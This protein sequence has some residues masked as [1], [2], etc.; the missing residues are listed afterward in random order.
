MTNIIFTRVFNFVYRI[1]FLYK[2]TSVYR[3]ELKALKIMHGFT[4]S[5]IKSRREELLK[6]KSLK[7][8]SENQEGKKKFAFLD[9]LLQ[10]VNSDGKPLTN[11]DIREEVDTFM[12][13]GHDTVTSGI[14]FALYNLAKYPAVQQKCWEEIRHVLGTDLEKSVNLR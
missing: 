8:E 1:E 13:E 4:D 7:V 5:V 12:F 2:L 6:E 9:I 3:K 11:M 10:S 14:S